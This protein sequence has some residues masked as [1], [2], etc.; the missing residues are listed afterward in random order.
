MLW[1]LAIAYTVMCVIAMSLLG[2]TDEE[3]HHDE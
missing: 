3:D 2:L 1:K